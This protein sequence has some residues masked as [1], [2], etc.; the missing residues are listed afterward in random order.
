MSF[1]VRKEYLKYLE[2]KHL[3]I[4]KDL[5]NIAIMIFS[6]PSSLFA[7]LKEIHT[8]YTFF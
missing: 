4:R 7:I 6:L 8:F 1:N 5:T 3:A 2:Q